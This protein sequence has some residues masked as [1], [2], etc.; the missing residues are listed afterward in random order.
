MRDQILNMLAIRFLVLLMA[1][2]FAPASHATL[3]PK[4]GGA[5][6][7]DSD[8]NLTWLA[9]ANLANTNTFGVSDIT[10]GLMNWNTAQSWINAINLAN[11]LGFKNWRLPSALN[12][13]GTGPCEGVNCTSSE[14][15]HMFYTELGGEAFASIQSIHN[16]I[17]YDMFTNI[18]SAGYSSGTLQVPQPQPPLP[19]YAWYLDFDS[20]N[21]T[22]TPIT[23]LLYAWAVRTGDVPALPDPGTLWLLG[24]GMAAWAS[25]RGRRRD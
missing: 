17:T 4:L 3:I 18:K 12:L 23:A 11:Y 7:Y 8:R 19:N 5:V 9:N 25:V 1:V 16:P 24:A 20:G 21:Q 13:A 6:V 15:G 22:T 14:M 10:N 2:V